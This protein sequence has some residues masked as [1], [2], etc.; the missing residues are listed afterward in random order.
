MLDVTAQLEEIMDEYS[1]EVKQATNKAMDTV[2]KEAVSKLK[3]SSPKRSGRYAS[4][5]KTK[6]EGGALGVNVVTVYNA[7]KPQLTHLLENGHL[8]RN[9]KGEFGRA[10]AHPHIASVEQWANSELPAEI[11]KELE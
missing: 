6:K 3:S 2:A 4:G 7:T 10:P 1:E 5:W 8:I 11:T 9:K